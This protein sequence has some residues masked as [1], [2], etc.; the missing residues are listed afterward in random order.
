LPN[1]IIDRLF[2]YMHAQHSELKE[3]LGR[4]PT[5]STGAYCLL[6]LIENRK[7]EYQRLEELRRD[8]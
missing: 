2:F 4:S 1:R 6:K 3:Q 8:R 5:L 7:A